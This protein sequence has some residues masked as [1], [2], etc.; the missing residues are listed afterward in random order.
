MVGAVE[1]NRVFGVGIVGRFIFELLGQPVPIRG[2]I[3]NK[4]QSQLMAWL[5]IAGAEFRRNIAR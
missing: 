3:S 2:R 5:T 4:G 1:D